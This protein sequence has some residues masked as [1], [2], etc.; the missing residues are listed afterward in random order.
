MAKLKLSQ[1]CQR[2]FLHALKQELPGKLHNALGKRPYYL[3]KIEH[4]GGVSEIRVWNFE[5]PLVNPPYVDCSDNWIRRNVDWHYLVSSS[6]F[7][8]VL[9]PE[10]IAH[11]EQNTKSGVS[12]IVQ[13]RDAARWLVG[14]IQLMLSR[15]WAGHEFG[16]SVWQS[17]WEDYS[18]GLDGLRE[19]REGTFRK[20]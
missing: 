2:L 13:S 8:W 19:F 9:D 15:H 18:H 11:F 5:N 14:A 3:G 6:R 16:L 10:W 12:L 17:G 4:D 7:C 20:S 1:V